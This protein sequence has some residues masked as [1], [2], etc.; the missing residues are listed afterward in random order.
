MSYMWSACSFSYYMLN[1]MMKYL[2]GNIYE[3]NYAL[4]VSEMFGC[5]ASGFV[6]RFLK[7]RWSFAFGYSISL[8]GGLLIFFLGHS[9][10]SL[11]PFF[12]LLARF[13]TTLNFTNC[14]IAQIDIFPT[15]FVGASFG[16]CNFIARSFTIGSAFAAEIPDPI[17]VLIY[18]VLT[19]IGLLASFF[20]YQE[21]PVVIKSAT[22]LK[23]D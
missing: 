5:V 15:L 2:P 19:G 12:V 4:G 7:A 14:Y 10:K 16:I 21:K 8:V 18:S 1:L 23:H 9:S 6:Y 3:N 11:M 17:P 22:D 20:I 13:G